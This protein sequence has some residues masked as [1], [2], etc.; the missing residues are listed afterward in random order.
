MIRGSAD[1]QRDPEPETVFG[2][3][4]DPACRAIVESL[5]EPMTA[6]E[7]SET[8]DVP[9]STTYKKLDR[10]QDASLVT[11]E[12]EFDPG[13]HHRARYTVEFDR[14]IVGLDETNEFAVDVESRLATPEQQ[15]LD[16]WAA[17]REES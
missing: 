13:G 12:T 5:D 11:E 9:L 3:L 7:V 15:L 17:I 14:V 1:D 10:L 16:V 4:D 2:T 8:A 6:R